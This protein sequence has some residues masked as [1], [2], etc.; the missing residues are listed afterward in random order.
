MVIKLIVKSKKL[1][2]TE[3]NPCDIELGKHFLD[4]NQNQS[5]KEQIDKFHQN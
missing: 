4:I 3:G 2:K 1:L 5:I